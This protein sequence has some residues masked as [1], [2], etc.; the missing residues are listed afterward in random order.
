MAVVTVTRD[1]WTQL[2]SAARRVQ[3]FGGRIQ[4]AESGTPAADDWLVFP[5]G[6]VVDVTANRWGRAVDTTP[7]WVVTQAV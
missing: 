3:V 4:V 2:N 7:T 6:A 1:A 5:E